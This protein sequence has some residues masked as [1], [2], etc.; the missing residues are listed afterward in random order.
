MR[1]KDIR[2]GMKIGLWSVIE[3]DHSFVKNHRFSLCKCECGTVNLVR[4]DSLARGESNGCHSCRARMRTDMK[5]HGLSK[6]PIFNNWKQM[7]ERCYNPKRDKYRIYGA[8]GIKVCDDWHDPVKFYEWAT[9]HGYKRDLTLDRIDV[10][11]DYCPENCRFITKKEQSRNTRYNRFISY[12]GE[13]H[14]LAEW[15]DILGL[16]YDNVWA[17]LKRDW[18]PEKAFTT[19]VRKLRR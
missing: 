3:A 1:G 18:E 16:D 7:M 4:N 14:C 8:R 6:T 15:V 5:V 11:G 10:N 2:T 19:P 9:T 13:T 12:E 17:R